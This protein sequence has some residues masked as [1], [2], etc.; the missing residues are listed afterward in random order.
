MPDD[1]SAY[2]VRCGPTR[3]LPTRHTSGAWSTTEQHISPLNGLVVHEIDRHAV[4]RANAPDDKILARLSYDIL[5]VVTIEEFDLSVATIRPGRT[6]ELVEATVR[7]HDRDV[8]RVR[9]WRLSRRDTSAVAG[10]QPEPIPHPQALR[11]SPLTD[12][13]P[14]GYIASLDVR[15]VGTP[16]PGRTRTWVAT[17][18]PILEGEEVGDLA[19]FVGLVDTANGIAVREDPTAWMFPNVDLSIHLYRQPEGGWVG[20]DTTVVFGA[21][22]TGL[23]TTTLHDADGPV[24]RAEQTLTIRPVEPRD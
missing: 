14:G 16:Q 10:G 8:C 18:I 12:I 22:G 23:T 2:F 4:G 11:P 7:Q 13:W 17:G 9:A 15:P 3:F 19:R 20:L 21:D 1:P 24:G 5:G 6:I